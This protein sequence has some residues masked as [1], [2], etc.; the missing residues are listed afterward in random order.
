[1]KETI[2][3]IARKQVGEVELSD[4]IFGMKAGSA[5]IYEAVKMQR[6]CAR[7]GTAATRNHKMVSGTS[8]KM[9]R[10]KGTGRARHGDARTNIFVGGG[11]AFGPHPRDYSYRLPKKARKG[12]LRAALSLKKQEGKL[13][14]LD[15]FPGT[16]IKTK[17]AVSA[18]SRLGVKS[19]LI[20][21]LDPSE[22]LVKSVRNIPGIKL[23]CCEGLNVY[24]LVSHEHAVIT[25]PALAKVEEVLGA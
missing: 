24:D 21:A 14:I 4:G 8:A 22:A 7:S 25:V 20:V 1:M 9:Y 6:A 23:L 2:L 15:E 13:L 16:R 5:L 3:N 10:Q 18:L 11:K 19:G 12:A 17:D